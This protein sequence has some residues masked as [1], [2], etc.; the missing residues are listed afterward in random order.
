MVVTGTFAPVAVDEI[1]RSLAVIDTREN[2][3][4]FNHWTDYLQLD[5]SV[6]LQQR[7]ADGVRRTYPF[8]VRRSRRR[9]CC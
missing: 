5:P 8:V 3:V 7:A 9:W 2:S 4:L 1:D 6:D